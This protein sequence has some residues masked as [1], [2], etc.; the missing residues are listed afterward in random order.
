[1]AR[2]SSVNPVVEAVEEVTEQAGS[3]FEQFVEYQRK[4]V[5]EATKA[6]SALV[7]DGVR[8]HGEKAV[9]EMVEGYRTLFNS[10]VDDLIKRLENVR[11]DDKP[12]KAEE[13]KE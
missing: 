12:V 7:P 4:A 13:A 10:T 9:R 2:K 11:M 6:F 3:P 1:M 8:E 5:E